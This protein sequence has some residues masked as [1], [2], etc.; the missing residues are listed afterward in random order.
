MRY[1][2]EKN[3]VLEAEVMSLKDDVEDAEQINRELKKEEDKV[4]KMKKKMEECG[5]YIRNLQKQVKDWKDKCKVELNCSKE[6]QAKVKQIDELCEFLAPHFEKNLKK[7]A[8][9]KKKGP[10]CNRKR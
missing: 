1:C 10:S 2:Q 7:I 3:A 5:L 8:K 4:K 6:L 9:E